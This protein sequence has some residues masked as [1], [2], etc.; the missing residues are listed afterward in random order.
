M[1]RAAPGRVEAAPFPGAAVDHE[2]LFQASPNP[3]VVLAPDLT[4]VAANDAYLRV[5]MR[6]RG[7]LI[8]RRMF[9]AFPSNPDSMREL[10]ASFDRVLAERAPDTLA[11]IHYDIS[12][13]APE[14][15]E[16]EE[17]Y[18]SAVN[19]PILN[20]RGEVA[21][22]LQH[23]VDVTRLQ[24]L[25]RAAAESEGARQGAGGGAGQGAGRAESSVFRRAEEVQ[26]ANRLLDAERLHLRRLFMQAPGFIAILRGPQHVFEL[27]NGAFSQ[28]IGHR[29]VVG[30][31]V[32]EALPEV[33]GQGFVELLDRV[34]RSGQAF[35]GRE[36]SVRLRRR[37][38]MPPVEAYV[39]FVYQPIV[40]EDGSV[41]GIFVQGSDVTE[42]RLAD[43]RQR[44]LIDELNHRV[45]N[46]LATVQS[47][48]MQTARNAS[49][50]DAFAEAFTARLIAL[51]RTHDALT[52]GNW[53]GADLREILAQELAPYGA[54]RR[55]GLR[56]G[57][58]RLP[59]RAA[60][61]LGMVFHELATN[62]AKHG[63]LAT[64]AGQI[65]VAWTTEPD[66]KA[67]GCRLR[68]EWVESG[69]PAG[70]PPG[71]RGFG[72]R[73]IEQSVAGE[74]D[75]EARLDFAPDGL[76]CSL[77][78]PLLP[79]GAHRE[80]AAGHHSSQTGL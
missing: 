29:D 72:S 5:T 24:R 67:G 71:R 36:L 17:R 6:R 23:T 70:A 35:V 45:K 4:I 3:Y 38:D 33:A 56:G 54:G 46:T 65:H 68:L 57:P 31:P 21:L 34:H 52:R 32:R 49:S 1:K 18:W 19:T 26:K 80:A 62:A 2:A 76:R 22:I 40:E 59:P 30:K 55:I 60:L 25:K 13:A 9:D 51:S 66:L 48:A 14:G 79:A 74:L 64:P 20:E 11:L 75:G 10:R 63:A 15:E 39:D 27:I 43:A 77:T 47:I 41:S 50:L 7:E 73:L 42:R 69:G 44:L 16:F 28:L 8:G 78:L 37:P 58:V 61:S 53:E 12:R